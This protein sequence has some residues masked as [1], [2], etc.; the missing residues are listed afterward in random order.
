[1]RSSAYFIGSAAVSKLHAIS[2]IACDTLAALAVRSVPALLSLTAGG[3]R[4]FALPLHG[5]GAAAPEAAAIFGLQTPTL[6][7]AAAGLRA[8]STHV[9][10]TPL[11]YATG[12]F[13]FGFWGSTQ[14][15]AQEYLV[16]LLRHVAVAQIPTAFELQQLPPCCV[17]HGFSWKITP[18]NVT[19]HGMSATPG[20][21]RTR[22]TTSSGRL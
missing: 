8:L 7:A 9:K 10:A 1:M 20:C 22:L 3:D 4:V 6:P 11:R 21:R 19:C 2:P 12:I 15:C 14:Q 5:A 16:A 17:Y 18:V 13:D